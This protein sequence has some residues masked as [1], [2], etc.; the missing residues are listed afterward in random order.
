MYR[1]ALYGGLDGQEIALNMKAT[2]THAAK[3]VTQFS[4]HCTTQY[5]YDLAT[6]QSLILSKILI[7]Y[8]P[9]SYI[10]RVVVLFY[11]RR[12]SGR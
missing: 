9:I 10:N 8:S 3:N 1:K 12:R 2:V 11:H 6:I 5:R 4:N 7:S